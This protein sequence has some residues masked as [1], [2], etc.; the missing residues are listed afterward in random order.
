MM[1][2]TYPWACL[3]LV[4]AA[5]GGL[6]PAGENWPNWRGPNHNGTADADEKNLPTTWGPKKNVV[7]QTRLPGP[8]G[9]TPVVWGDRV[10]VSTTD[11]R[12]TLA[13]CIAAG[14][15]KVLW[16]KPADREHRIFR[17]NMAAPSPA[18]DGKRAYFLYGTGKL[19][20]FDFDGREVWSRSVLA[21]GGMPSIKFG[22]SSSPLIHADRLYVQVVQ[23]RQ[24]RRYRYS[25]GGRS[26]VTSYLLAIDPATGKDLWRQTRPT[27]AI[28]EAQESYATPVPRKAGAREEI[29]VMGGNHVTAHEPATGR[30]LWR[31]GPYNP[32]R[33]N[34]YR[35]VPSPVDCDGLIVVCAPRDDPVYAF[36]P[37]RIVKGAK[38]RVA[39]KLTR[40]PSDVCTPLYYGKL[41]YILDGDSKT[42]TC[43]DPQTGKVKWTGSLGG[44]IF[45]ASPTGA[46]GKIYCID[47]AGN[48]T[49]LKA[50]GSFRVLARV[51]MGET[52]CY[53]TI[54]AVGGRLY[55]RTGKSLYCIG[56]AKPAA[57]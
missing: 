24:G 23:N 52:P 29:L 54:V 35:V 51:S 40:H 7:W 44:R 5:S 4:F 45:R 18:T 10:F 14:D 16:T 27:D 13:V 57:G 15:G 42:M 32:E 11:S 43:I 49:V 56:A 39:W 38:P 8:C 22:Y 31:W 9:A 50:G 2:N 55:V 37:E 1:K 21:A 3:V 47:T 53:A 26:E 17:N 36:R 28:D 48:V 33:K 12:R 6:A 34:I 30:E 20:A 25:P 46:D 41:V 19:V